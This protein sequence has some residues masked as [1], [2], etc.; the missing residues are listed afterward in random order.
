M[1]G[2]KGPKKAEKQLVV[3]T[4]ALIYVSDKPLSAKHWGKK[5]LDLFEV[6]FEEDPPKRLNLDTI[7]NS[8]GHE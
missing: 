3:P 1:K 7:T 8:N 6:I 5:E 2:G 4:E